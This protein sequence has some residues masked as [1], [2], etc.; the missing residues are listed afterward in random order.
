[1][2]DPIRRSDESLQGHGLSREL[3]AE[4]ADGRDLP[5]Q[6]RPQDILAD[7]E[8]DVATLQTMQ[9]AAMSAFFFTKASR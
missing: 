4:T 5:R 6:R 7:I 2:A 3:I 1:M 8:R 9:L